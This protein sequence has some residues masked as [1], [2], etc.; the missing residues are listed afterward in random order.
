[1]AVHEL[2][3]VDERPFLVMELVEGLDLLAL[4][5]ATQARDM[6]VPIEVALHIVLEVALA[7]A[8]A[9]GATDD[10]GALLGLVHRDVSP[11]NVLIAW[12]GAVKLTDFG[13]ARWEGRALEPTPHG[14]FRG[15]LL[16]MAPERLLGAPGDARS[17]VYSLG[18]LL[19]FLAAGKSPLARK[20]LLL[21]FT[22]GRTAM[23][24]HKGLPPE[25][26]TLIEHATFRDPLKRFPSALDMAQALGR[27]LLRCSSQDRH[28]AMAEWLDCLRTVPLPT[29]A[30]SS[31][32]SRPSRTTPTSSIAG[33]PR[34]SV[35]ALARAA[36][37]AQTFAEDLE[38]ARVAGFDGNLATPPPASSP[39]PSAP[40]AGSSGAMAVPS[41]VPSPPRLG[42]LATLTAGAVVALALLL[43]IL[44]GG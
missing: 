21:A 36:K 13:V 41:R 30:E 43:W 11:R 40:S 35:R 14:A 37:A 17:D 15:T 10:H 2:G 27:A 25:V 8:Y 39:A 9:H 22:T 23:P 24:I 29:K 5:D 19:H 26:R 31:V 6:T 3:V 20:D 1:V 7:L 4:R 32:P 33:P 18:C 28:L 16:Y 38:A 44:L 12:N 34:D 42:L